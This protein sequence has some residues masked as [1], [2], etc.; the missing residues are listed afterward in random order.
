VA[1]PW[2]PL[3]AFRYF[4]GFCFPGG[5]RALLKNRT[6]S[7]WI[8]VPNDRF[9]YVV[10]VVMTKYF[11]F[12][13]RI[14]LIA[15]P[16]DSPLSGN[17][18]PPLFRNVQLPILDEQSSRQEKSG[19]FLALALPC[20]DS[21]IAYVIPSIPSSSVMNRFL[22][23]VLDSPQNTSPSPFCP[24]MIIFRRLCFALIFRKIA[25]LHP[26]L[27]TVSDFYNFFTRFLLR[28]NLSPQDADLRFFRCF[29]F[30]PS[31]FLFSHLYLYL[32]P[33]GSI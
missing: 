25:D 24:Q 31:F 33:P 11:L 18:S 26:P 2:E 15:K 12:C 27:K 22:L 21:P 29:I 10:S 16:L 8:L 6:G 14:S 19:M 28:S 32:C 30:S 13:L 1:P 5:R 9:G 4:Y 7:A 17:D 3:L 23:P 20:P